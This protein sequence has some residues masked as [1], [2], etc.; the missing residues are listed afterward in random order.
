[1][2]SLL[3]WQKPHFIISAFQSHIIL[4]KKNSRF[5]KILFICGFPLNLLNL[6]RGKALLK[7]KAN[8]EYYRTHRVKPRRDRKTRNEQFSQTHAPPNN[9]IKP[10][11]N[12]LTNFIKL[13]LR[14]LC[15]KQ[16]VLAAKGKNP[17][18]NVFIIKISF[19]KHFC[20]LLLQP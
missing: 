16:G 18:C 19:L 3:G 8:R 20:Y 17:S 11:W 1:M 15:S 12:V 14:S 5:P 2:I 7:W 9:Y 13:C 10:K 6:E 4:W